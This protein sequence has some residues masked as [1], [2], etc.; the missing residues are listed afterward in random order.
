MRNADKWI[1]AVLVSAFVSAGCT[2]HKLYRADTK[3]CVSSQPAQDCQEQA[4]QEFKDPAHPDAGY[5]LGFIEFDDQGQVFER[6]QMD[7]VLT[8]LQTEAASKNLLMVVFVHGWK[9]SAAPGDTNIETFRRSLERISE[10]ESRISRETGAEARK[11][12]GI[13]LGWRGGSITWPGVKELTFWDRKNTAHKV[14]HGGV[15]EVVSRLELVRKTKDA[16]EGEQGRSRTRLVVIGHSFGGAVVYSA[17]SQILATGFVD[18]VGPAGTITDVKG[19]GDLV[20][21][22]NPAF[23]ATLFTSLSDMANERPTYFP[24]QL[25][26]IAVL[27]SEAD[28]ATKRAFP[29]G[30][31]FS[32]FFEKHREETRKNGVTGEAEVIDQKK[33]NITAVGHFEPYRTHF[34][35]AAVE[36]GVETSDQPSVAAS[37]ERFFDVSGRWEND[38]PGSVIEFEGSVLARTPNSAG[39]NP[40]LVIR[41][42][43]QL[44]RDHND[45]DDWRIASFVRQLILI[46]G[47]SEDLGERRL[48]RTRA[49]RN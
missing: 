41:V 28:D 22:I 32:T 11:V 13:Y 26:V 47:Q 10:L 17:L 29:M 16:M 24:A 34:L 39:R 35:R 38:A 4:L 46:A 49:F 27:T 18:T 15:T 9:H 21:L 19:F 1:T 48:M 8:A 14:G 37:V 3:I 5:L 31:W 20:V 43:E 6:Q 30:R 45:I 2:P 42:D 12:V 40:Y 23:E 44:I 25:P 33:A 36:P 7:A